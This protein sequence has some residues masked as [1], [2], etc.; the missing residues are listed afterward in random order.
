VFGCETALDKANTFFGNGTAEWRLV[1]V[2]VLQ[3]HVLEEY[4][5]AGFWK[6][7]Q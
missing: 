4:G 5:Q 3:F 7:F 1:K 6:G 2:I